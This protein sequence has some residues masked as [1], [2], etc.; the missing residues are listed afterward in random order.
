[1][2]KASSL[3][4][5]VVALLAGLSA[6]G[7]VAQLGLRDDGVQFPDGTVQTSAAKTP[8]EFVQAAGSVNIPDLAECA[9]G[10]IYTV[11]AGKRLRIEWIGFDIF[12][13]GATDFTPVDVALGTWSGGLQILFPLN[14]IDGAQILGS[15]PA[16]TA[17][18]SS[19]VTL[20]SEAAQAVSLR[21]CRNNN[22][23]DTTVR[24]FFHGQLFDA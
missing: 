9:T 7:A 23:D 2:K 12:E 10:D 14:R 6:G 8:G 18:S 1:M 3:F 24:V 19:Q 5:M 20:Y 4:L 22:T 17:R 11:P 21:T 13:V 15:S 16:G